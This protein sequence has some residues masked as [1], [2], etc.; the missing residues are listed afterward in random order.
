[1]KNLPRGGLKK[2]QTS[3]KVEQNN[4]HDQIGQ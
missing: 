1:M 2:R 4:N 3:S